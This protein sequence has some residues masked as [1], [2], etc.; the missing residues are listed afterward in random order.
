MGCSPWG[1]KE[2]DSTERL[3]QKKKKKPHLLG[4]LVPAPPHLYMDI[5][6]ITLVSCEDHVPKVTSKCSQCLNLFIFS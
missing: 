6:M 5:M 1:H 4:L 3:N 2:S